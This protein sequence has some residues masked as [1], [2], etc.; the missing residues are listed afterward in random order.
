MYYPLRTWAKAAKFHLTGLQ[1]GN[2]YW[3]Y[4]GLERAG[5]FPDVRNFRER[6]R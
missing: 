1:R 6:A 5:N 3:E 2:F 4:A